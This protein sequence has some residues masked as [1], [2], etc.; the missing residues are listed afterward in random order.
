MSFVSSAITSILT[1]GIALKLESKEEE[2]YYIIKMQEYF[3]EETDFPAY[4]R[5]KN[6]LEIEDS[7]MQLAM[8]LMIQEST[9]YLLPYSPDVLEIFTEVLKFIANNHTKIISGFRGSE[10]IKI[11]SPT[12]INKITE[13]EEEKQ[14]YEEGSSDDD[15]FE[16]I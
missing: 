8:E 7:S 4:L 3:E 5:G 6:T 11:E 9:L 16:W 14:Q 13:H 10:E 1:N 15:D 12:D 2:E